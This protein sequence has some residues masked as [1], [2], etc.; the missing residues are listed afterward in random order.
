MEERSLRSRLFALLRT[1]GYALAVMLAVWVLQLVAGMVLDRSWSNLEALIATGVAGVAAIS[2]VNLLLARFLRPPSPWSGWRSRR[3]GLKGFAR[4]AAMGLLM[5]GGVIL[6]LLLAGNASIRFEGPGL[7]RYA[8]AL[9]PASLA[10]LPAALW[11]ELLFRGY[12]LAALSRAVGVLGAA[13]ATALLFSL[14]HSAA[15]PYP[16]ATVNIFLIGLILAQVRLGPGGM[17]AAW[18]L[19]FAW[20]LLLLLS[21]AEI[22][23]GDFAPKGMVYS[24]TGPVWLTGG[25][26][27]PEG[28]VVTS[29]VALVTSV[30][31]LVRST[32]PE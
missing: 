2:A 31:L 20:N 13:F 30:L 8:L 3:G 1:V 23:G 19:H 22:S 16:I 29:C 15:G 17:P 11:E 12:P 14:V 28:S 24:V 5:A 21:G 9:L 7:P 32:R 6:V 25:G 18:G 27:G 4:G 26:F 10:L